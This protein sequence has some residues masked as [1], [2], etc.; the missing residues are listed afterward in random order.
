ML[1]WR[2]IPATQYWRDNWPW[3]TVSWVGASKYSYIALRAR[4]L[5]GARLKIPCAY[6]GVVAF[7]RVCPILKSRPQSGATHDGVDPFPVGGCRRRE[8]VEVRAPVGLLHVTLIQH[9]PSADVTRHRR[10]PVGS[11]S[12]EF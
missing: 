7:G 5:R 12:I 9:R 11:A 8:E 10:H 3:R 2:D 6:L 4:R 1:F